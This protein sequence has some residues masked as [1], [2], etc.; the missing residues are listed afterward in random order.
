MEWNDIRDKKDIFV[1]E[2]ALSKNKSILGICRGI[3]IL[4]VTLNG[5]LYQDLPTQYRSKINHHMSAPYDRKC[6]SAYLLK[7]TPLYDLIGKDTINVNSIH[8][9]AIKELSSQLRP[10]TISSDGLIEAVYMPGKKFVWSVQCHPEYWYQTNEDCFK[11]F[12]YFAD[13][14]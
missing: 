10:M 9:Q 4:N 6:H 7:S 5:D 1:I 11:I 14:L 8:H 13:N 3:Q 2:Y 12:A